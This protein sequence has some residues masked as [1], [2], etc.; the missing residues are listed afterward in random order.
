MIHITHNVPADRVD[1]LVAL[2]ESSGGRLQ[3]KAIEEDGEF[4]LVFEFPD[5]ASDPVTQAAVQ[6]AATALVATP[7]RPGTSAAESGARDEPRWL[8]IARQ[9]LGE[10]ELPGPD[11]NPRIVAYHASTRDGAAPD[12]VPWCAS[13]V[14]WCLEEAGMVGSDS[15]L[16][17]SWLGWGEPINEPRLGCIVVLERGAA[18]KGHVGFYLGSSA[19]TVT[20]LG[21]NQGDRVSVA[22]FSA[23]RVIGLRWPTSG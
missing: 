2:A 13:F 16:A 19:G 4:T 20:L 6:P 8:R 21:G 7:T 12:A 10:G 3:S 9:A 5:A 11:D 18:P 23:E 14:N 1:F 17:R 22:S 15:K